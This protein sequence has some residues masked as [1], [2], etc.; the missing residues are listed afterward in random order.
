M[1]DRISN[2]RAPLFVASALTAATIG[3]LPTGAAFATVATVDAV[4][5]TVITPAAETPSAVLAATPWE[6]TSA[7]DQ[8]GANIPLTDANVSNYAG[9]AYYNTNGTF[10]IYNTDDT[11]KIKG[12]WSV[13]PD[14]SSRTLVAKDNAGNTLFTR[15]V[16]ITVLTNTNFT[17]RV[18]PTA[19]NTA[20]YYDII[21]T[22]TT[23][24]EPVI[25]P[26]AV[27]A[28]TP[29]E[30]TSAK[31]QTG[32][33]IP[34]TDANVSNYAGWAYYNTNGTFAI[35]NTD[36]T[37]KIKGDW[38]VTPD[39]SSRTLVA[40]DNAGN[41]L[42]TRVVPITVLTNTNFT[43]RVYPTAGNTA[44]YYDIIHTPTTHPEPSAPI[45][46]DPTDP[47]DPTDPKPIPTDN[48]SGTQ[49][50]P[51]T[52]T[53]SAGSLAQTGAEAPSIGLILG[54]IATLLGGAALMFRRLT[55][56]S[57]NAG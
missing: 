11:P 16:P 40:K 27:L 22:P 14:G 55:G 31:D 38:S 33:N 4:A 34:L 18:Y 44:V 52:N 17:Y 39:G 3:L 5:S 46:P 51:A 23:H 9:W 49:P 13:T 25:S 2:S 48:G 8:T 19:G 47:T 43:Y 7:K 41:T 20:V 28:A 56:R 29:W 6:T 26:S 32:A 45:D 21:H 36:D 57:G 15:V 37:P 50:A 12:D 42:F 30:T 54:S 35:Y 10:A 1:R 53:G 24:A